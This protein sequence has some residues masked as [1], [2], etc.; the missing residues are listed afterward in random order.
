MPTR[1]LSGI[2]VVDLTVNVPGP[3]CSMMLADLG[4]RVVKVEPPGGDPLRRSTA[5][6]DGLNRGKES[7]VLDLKTEAG[8]GGLGGL[9][10]TADIVLEGW[11]PGVASRLGADYRR[12]PGAAAPATISTTLP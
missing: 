5:M 8:R 3:F 1:P 11:R 10:E 12:V 2:T 4:A 6:W 9:A 7:V